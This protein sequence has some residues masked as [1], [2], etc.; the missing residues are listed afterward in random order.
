MASW[1]VLVGFVIDETF[2]SEVVRQAREHE[3]GMSYH[4]RLVRDLGCYWST[5]SDV[6]EKHERCRSSTG[7][8]ATWEL[9]GSPSIHR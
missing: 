1:A 8:T 7:V 2:P 6:A 3:V 5:V 4:V 9:V